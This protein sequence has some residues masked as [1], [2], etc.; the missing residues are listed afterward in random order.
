MKKIGLFVIASL[1]MFSSIS[2]AQQ[3]DTKQPASE[4]KAVP[5]VASTPAVIAAPTVEAPAKVAASTSGLVYLK[6]EKATVSSFDESPDWAPK[7]EPMAVVDGDIE[8]CKS[9]GSGPSG[10]G[11]WRT[12]E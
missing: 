8:A 11:E 1:F 2:C 6:A 12:G 10:A 3:T 9:N 7:P 4:A 5:V